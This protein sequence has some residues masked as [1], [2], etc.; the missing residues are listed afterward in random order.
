MKFL[1]GTCENIYGELLDYEIIQHE[2]NSLTECR[3]ERRIINY[4]KWFLFTILFT[5]LAALINIHQIDNYLLLI[6][7][8]ILL[9]GVILKAYLK[10]KRG[11][12]SCFCSS[13]AILI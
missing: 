1:G 9:I 12:K 7:S 3:L 10:V 13:N 5:Y 11:R 6:L 4:K 8:I 2:Q